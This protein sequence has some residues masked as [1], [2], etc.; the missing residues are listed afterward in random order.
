MKQLDFKLQGRIGRDALHASFAIGE[1]RWNREHPRA[2]HLHAGDSLIPSLDDFG[3]SKSKAK[4][5]LAVR[6][7]ERL[8]AGKHALVV[9]GQRVAGLAGRALSDHDVLLDEFALC[10]CEHQC[11]EERDQDHKEKGTRAV[12]SEV[13]KW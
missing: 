10:W 4:R 8:T 1:L 11:G 12:G 7:V 3:R 13:M 2:P 6:A 9:D 5:R